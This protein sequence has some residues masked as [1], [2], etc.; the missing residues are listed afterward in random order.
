VLQ[1]RNLEVFRKR[2]AATGML[3]QAEDFKKASGALSV[4]CYRE[5]IEL[6]LR[7][8]GFSGFQ[9]LDLQDY[10]G[11]GTALVGI[12]DAFMDS[13]G[14]V[15]SEKW[16]EF[17]NDIVPLAIFSKYCWTNKET[18]SAKIA[19]AHYGQ[20]D[21]SQE[22]IICR[23]ETQQNKILY[24]QVLSQRNI[25]QGDVVTIDSI[26]IALNKIKSNQKLRFTVSLKNSG[27]KNSW[28]LWVYVQSKNPIQEGNIGNVLV[29][30]NKTQCDRV[31]A[32]GRP[33][34]YIPRHDEIQDNSVGG[35]FISD[36]WNY[37]M[38]RRISVGRKIEVS[39]GTLG[40][41]TDPNHAM[42]KL[43]PTDF[44][45]NW[46]WW[47]IIKHSRPAILNQY[48]TDYKPVVQAIDNIQRLNKLGLIYEEPNTKGKVLVCTSDLFEI[49]NE[50]EAQ[51][52]FNSLVEY[53]KKNNK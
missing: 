10:P 5:E 38:F 11:Q 40:I 22:D 53:L 16:R 12:L 42:F 24:E 39:P 41:L 25:K 34:L 49:K 18:F 4:L 3:P 45:S 9:L 6:A 48:P 20:K 2:L 28:D 31:A 44:H 51:A 47:S 37:D 33:V 32:S 50:P 13:K 29:T 8:P 21:L 7:T 17:C 26:Q 43:F 1:A 35:L 15:E 46:Q 52:L 27:Y 14:I 23:L 30:R 36:F 19:V